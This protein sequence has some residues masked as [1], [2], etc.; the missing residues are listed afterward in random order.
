MIWF[1]RAEDSTEDGEFEGAEDADEE[2]EEEDEEEEP[3]GL[4]KEGNDILVLILDT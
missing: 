2:E 4:G 1:F 3:N